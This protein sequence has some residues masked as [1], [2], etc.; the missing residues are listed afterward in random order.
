VCVCGATKHLKRAKRASKFFL[1][2][3]QQ[4]GKSF[5]SFFFLVASLPRITAA[6]SRKMGG[7]EGVAS[8]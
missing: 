4:P 3:Q 1:I 7:G 2:F 6:H 8:T 5:P